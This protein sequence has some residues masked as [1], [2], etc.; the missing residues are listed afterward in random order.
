MKHSANYTDLIRQFHA[1]HPKGTSLRELS[2]KVYGLPKGVMPSYDQALQLHE[3]MLQNP[4]KKPEPG[5]R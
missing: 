2:S 4:G 5:L 3:W 1:T